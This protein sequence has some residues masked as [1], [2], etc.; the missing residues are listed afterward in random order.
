MTLKFMSELY[1]FH[2]SYSGERYEVKLERESLLENWFVTV[3]NSDKNATVTSYLGEK[4]MVPD[5]HVAQQILED[6]VAGDEL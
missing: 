1:L 6:N 2:F 5:R 4:T 3:I